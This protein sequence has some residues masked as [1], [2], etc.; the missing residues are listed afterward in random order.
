MRVG[1]RVKHIFSFSFTNRRPNR[2]A[3][4]GKSPVIDDSP[5]S[6]YSDDDDDAIHIS[7]DEGPNSSQSDDDNDDDEYGATSSSRY[8]RVRIISWR[9][10]NHKMRPGRCRWT[11]EQERRLQVAQ[12]ELARC[13]KAWS[14]EQEVWLKHVCQRLG[15]LYLTL[16]KT[17]GLT[18][19]Y[20]SKNS[21]KRKKP[22]RTF[23]ISAR[24]NSRMSVCI[25]GRR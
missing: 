5:Y 7:E 19:D 3:W 15:H 22:T 21:T 8:K 24:S 4:K 1:S 9:L 17:N 16:K 10:D 23:Y 25:S 12:Q 20:R 18:H 13:Q 14:S 2:S 6:S 11:L